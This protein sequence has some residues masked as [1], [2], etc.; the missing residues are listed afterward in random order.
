MD[1]F[2]T[3]EWAVTPEDVLWRR[4]KAGL[5]LTG[6]QREAVLRHMGRVS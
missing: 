2:V 1:Y 6:A 3:Q 5:H 4:T